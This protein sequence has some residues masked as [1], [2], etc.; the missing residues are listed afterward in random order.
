MVGSAGKLA[1]RYLFVVPLIALACCGSAFGQA[2]YKYKGPDG[3][4]IFSD[5]PP[6]DESRAEVRELPQG[7]DEAG[8]SVYH[9]TSY[10]AFSFVAENKFH[11][12]VEVIIGLDELT[13]L[14][15]PPP[16]LQ[17]RWV[18]PAR[19]RL[20]LMQLDILDVSKQATADY[21][22]VWLPGEPGVEHQPAEPYRA[23][24]AVANHF[25]VSQAFPVG[26]THITP[27]SHHA[28]DLVMPVGTDIYAARSGTVF[29]VASTNFRGG[30][31]PNQQFSAANVVQ[32]L[33]DD[34]TFAIYGHLNWNS[35][36]VTPGDQ[37]LRG[38]F[39]AESG[40]TGFSSGPHLHFAVIRN[41]GMG[42][43]SMPVIFEGPNDA[44][45]EV[46]TG[47]ELTAY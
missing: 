36:R 5:R 26:V 30:V 6:Q 2:L 31:D 12:P 42:L 4:W 41:R 18:I 32:I 37:V 23:P 28:V 11:A 27:D 1:S 13:N 29:Q 34:G 7:H 39:I 9:L 33:H 47:D 35:I 38:Q 16:E 14:T 17:M 25:L 44:I 10:G 40:N 46:E 20:T 22:Y 45:V 8:V 3:D 21:R 19:S 43:E 24:F 15:L